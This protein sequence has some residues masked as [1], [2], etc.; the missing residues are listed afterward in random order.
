MPL[1]S[2]GLGDFPD[3]LEFTFSDSVLLSSISTAALSVN[4]QTPPGFSIVDGQTIVF[5][6]TGLNQSDGIYTVQLLADS[7][8]DIHGNPLAAFNLSFNYDSV[9][10]TVSAISIAPDAVLPINILDLRVT[11]SEAIC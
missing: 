8:F 6:L 7:L 11:F 3:S 10:P 9:A 5:D 1:W 2:V 4:G